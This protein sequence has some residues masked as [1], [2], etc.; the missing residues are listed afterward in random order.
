MKTNVEILK[1]TDGKEISKLV[2]GK[3]I[4]DAFEE[5]FEHSVVCSVNYY[6]DIDGNKY[7]NCNRSQYVKPLA[8]HHYAFER[9]DIEPASKKGGKHMRKFNRRCR[10]ERMTY[11]T[12]PDA[13]LDFGRNRGLRRRMYPSNAVL[14]LGEDYLPF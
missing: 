6:V 12:Y 7:Y 4:G 3:R 2:I 5:D 14:E 1:V 11:P 10:V 13:F 8:G 9:S